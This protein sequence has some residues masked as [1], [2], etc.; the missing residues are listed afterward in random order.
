MVVD[1]VTVKT[2]KSRKPAGATPMLSVSKKDQY[3]KVNRREAARM[4]Q[5]V[6]WTGLPCVNGH[7]EFR[8]VRNYECTRCRVN[9]NA[10]HNPNKMLAIDRLNEEREAKKNDDNYYD[11]D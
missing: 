9:T 10:A 7:I 11:E 6:Y 2:T 5:P 3:L 4:K 8:Y 1:A